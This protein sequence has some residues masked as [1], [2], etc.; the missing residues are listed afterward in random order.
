MSSRRAKSA[1]PILSFGLSSLLSVRRVR[2]PGP[3]LAHTLLP[4]YSQDH[5]MASFRPDSTEL[6]T[7]QAACKVGQ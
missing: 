2:H 7:R 1:A 6:G 5:R 3:P 4:T